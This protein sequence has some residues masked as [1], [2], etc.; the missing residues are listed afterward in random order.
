MDQHF[1][2]IEQILHSPKH[3]VLT[4]TKNVLEKQ[5][6]PD[7]AIARLTTAVLSKSIECLENEGKTLKENETHL[8]MPLFESNQSPC[9]K[10]QN[11]FF[12]P[13]HSEC[14]LPD[15]KDILSCA[16]MNKANGCL[17]DQ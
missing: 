15:A 10:Q 5:E 13:C 14:Y 4:L 17:M 9:Q 1:Q 12:F 6:R 8:D 16:V 3:R 11:F 7:N 2:V